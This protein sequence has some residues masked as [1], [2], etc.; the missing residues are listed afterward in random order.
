MINKKGVKKRK[1]RRKE[2]AVFRKDSGITLVALV[3]TIVVLLILAGITIYVLFNKDGILGQS[4][5]ASEQHEIESIRE[6]LEIINS[7]YRVERAVDKT[8]NREN[9]WKKLIQEQ[10]IDG[11]DAIGTPEKDGTDD[12]YTIVTNKGYEVIVTVEENENIIIGSIRKI[13]RETQLAE[14]LAFKEKSIVIEP[15]QT[16]KLEI[17]I[18]PQN[19]TNTRL[20]WTSSNETVATV[21]DGM[22]TAKK[23]GMTT[24]TAV[25]T[26]GSNL[27]AS[28]T[29]TVR[30]ILVSEKIG[31][32]SDGLIL[33]YDGLQNTKEGHDFQAKVWEDLS[34]NGRD[35][36]LYGG[37]TWGR[38]GLTL[39]GNDDGVYIG[40]QLK[41][42]FKADNTIEITV[43]FDE[44]GRDII[45]GNYS[46]ANNINYEKYTGNNFRT[47]FNNGTL[48]NKSSSD[49]L[50]IGSFQTLTYVMNKEEGKIEIYNDTN[51]VHLVESSHIIDYNANWTSVWVGKDS[52]T[53]LTCLK[54]RIASVRVY[55][56]R[57]NNEEIAKNNE[58]DKQRF[59]D[60]KMTIQEAKEQ[61][62]SSN[63]REFIGTEVDYQTEKGGT[64]RIFYLDVEGAFSPKDSIILKRDLSV[65]AACIPDEHY[66]YEPNEEIIERMK[67]ADPA[68]A[69]S[70]Y[71][72]SVNSD[73]ERFLAWCC[74]PSNWTEFWDKNSSEFISCTPSL[75]LYITSLSTVKTGLL[76]V[77]W[78]S[79]TVCRYGNSSYN[80][81]IGQIPSSHNGIYYGPNNNGVSMSSPT[82]YRPGWKWICG[83]N[84][85]QGVGLWAR[86]GDEVNYVCPIVYLK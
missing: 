86:V 47:Y 57:L 78:S 76:K 13:K 20:K 69:K 5:E 51:K 18:T 15:Q 36:T 85:S 61:I 54:G 17:E 8:V 38:L 65:D 75:D 32:V 42:L 30:N 9:F 59:I 31:Y 27:T 64:W 80:V 46:V 40:D 70:S 83:L 19:T 73:E 28:C 50:S 37:G 12:I 48:D 53:G 58:I 63:F 29:I 84:G 55:N 14:G 81:L 11:K 44:K 68:W 67:K 82:G 52:R 25:T 41:D 35:A 6:Q 60:K 10:I 21:K 23:E 2:E 56:R 77:S 24:I 72:N 22:V 33:H 4:K 34:E 71:S 3:V 66:N 1:M 79:D 26:D 39:D 49:T 62:N 74:D 43:E 16:R 45:I 7:D